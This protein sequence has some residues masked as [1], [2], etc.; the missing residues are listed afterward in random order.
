MKKVILSA[1]ILMSTVAF[2]GTTYT[3][4]T[5]AVFTQVQGP[6]N[7]GKA[8]KDPDGTLWS[9]YQGMYANNAV[10]PDQND[11]VVDSPATEACANI[12][13][14]LPTA[15]QYEK[16]ATYFNRDLSN[17]I[18]FT[19]TDQGRKDLYAIFPDMENLTLNRINYFWSSSVASY[20]PYNI[21]AFS[22]LTGH[23]YDFYSVERN[24]SSPVLCVAL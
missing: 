16:L 13:G 14:L 5:G 17:L 23:I 15:Q 11:V 19:F 4:S 6:G 24:G 12:G 18:F 20:N 3:T 2:A 9:S 1:S 10:K 21:Y 8:W 7:F 22:S